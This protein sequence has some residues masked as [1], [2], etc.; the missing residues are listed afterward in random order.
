M[1]VRRV[2]RRAPT[3]ADPRT[4]ESDDAKTT[5]S[6]VG[7]R[8]LHDHD[9][10]S[11]PG[12]LL[13][14]TVVSGLVDAVS[15]LRL[16]HVFVANMTG[17][18]VFFGLGL[19]RVPGFSVGVSLTA[20]AGF[21]L[22]A[23]GTGYL[24]ARW[25]S[26]RAKLLRTSAVTK[27][28]LVAPALI[29]AVVAGIAPNHAVV[30]LFTA[31]LAVSMGVQNATVYLLGVPDLT[32]TVLTTTLTRLLS[33]LRGGKWRDVANGYRAASI[34]C[35]VSGA[36]IGGVLVLEVD[37]ASALGLSIALLAAVGFAAHRA[38]VAHAGWASFRN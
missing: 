36:F 20:L 13:V 1:R 30:Y 14:L 35:L 15:L 37:A 4:P 32:T 17:N 21:V 31:L 7:Q 3:S 22:G 33:D 24:P 34:L 16:N 6:S 27:V 12:L 29:T 25:R 28:A 26:D 18:I 19:A 23:A 10:G 5:I 38:V 9:H 8:L 11:L 2:G